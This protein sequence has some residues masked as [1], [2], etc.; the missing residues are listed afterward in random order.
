[1][2]NLYALLIGINNYPID[3]HKL[4][5]CINDRNAMNDFFKSYCETNDLNYQPLLLSDEEAT[6]QGIIDGFEQFKDA[7]TGDLC[8]LYFSGHGSQMIAPK[9]F[10][11]DE[12]DQRCETVV[13]HDSRIGKGRDLSDKELSYLIW[14]YTH[15]KDVHFLATFD[16]CHAGTITRSVEMVHRMAEV[17]TTPVF[18][19]R[20]EGVEFYKSHEGQLIPPESDHIALSASR[21]YESSVELTLG[22]Q[23]RGLFTY[24]LIDVLTQT[25]LTTLSYSGLMSKVQTRVHSRIDSQHP[26]VDAQG[27]A[28]IKQL[29]LD[30][31]LKTNPSY[32]VKHNEKKGWVI[33]LGTIHGMNT[34]AK[35]QLE[36]NDEIKNISLQ[37]IGT[38]QSI[39]R[40]E[41]WMKTDD[42]FYPIKEISGLRKKVKIAFYPKLENP[43]AKQ[44]IHDFVK[45]WNIE[46]VNDIDAAAYWM[47]LT[48]DGYILTRPH[49]SRPVFKAIPEES[50]EELF[51][52]NV[53]KVA[54]WE[55][56][57]QL[58]N[59]LA[60]DAAEQEL[61]IDF[62]QV[63]DHDNY[64]KVNQEEAMDI[65]GDAVF[66]YA[67]NEGKW[68]N[69]NLRMSVSN[70][71]DRPLW[72][73]ALFLGE[74][75]VITDYFMPV[76]ELKPNQQSYALTA[77]NQEGIRVNVVP[78]YVPDELHSWGE[79]EISNQIKIIASATP[80]SMEAY[81]QEGLELEAKPKEGTSRGMGFGSPKPSLPKI[82]TQ[83]D[84]F[85]KDII[86][87]IHRS[88]DVQEAVAGKT[89]TL[90]NLTIE[91]HDSFSAKKIRLTSS[92]NEQ[93]GVSRGVQ[94]PSIQNVLG[95][96][97]FLPINIG[98]GS[99]S[100]QHGLDTL[101]LHDV[102]G[103]ENVT[104]ENPLRLKLNLPLKNNE[105][106]FPF[107]YDAETNTYYP[108]GYPEDDV[109]KVESLADAEE[110][111][112]RGLGRSFKIYLQKVVYQKLFKKEFPFPVLAAATVDEQ[113]NVTYEND[114]DVIKN[115]VQNPDNQRIIIFIHG[116]IGD[117]KDQV[118]LVRRAVRNEGGAKVDLTNHYDLVLTF[119]Y[120]SLN[121]PIE[122]TAEN[123]KKRLE[124]IGLVAG[125]NK[126]LHII[127]HS[128]GGLVSRWFIEKLG[129][130]QIVTHFIQVG[131]PNAGSPWAKAYHMGV[132]GLTKLI[133]FLPIPSTINSVLSFIGKKRKNVEVTVGQLQPD[134]DFSK[135]LNS[136]SPHVKI[137]YTILAGDSS[138]IPNRQQEATLFKKMLNRYSNEYRKK[139][140]KLFFHDRSD[141]IVAVASC[142]GI[143]DENCKNVTTVDSVGCNHFT[144]FNTDE[145]VTALAKILF[146]IK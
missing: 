115:K 24:S 116:I 95:S 55:E 64:L 129:G 109:I 141:D 74:D 23:R 100:I 1:M 145:G 120:E 88:Q 112:T 90:Q 20:F 57:S 96:D 70:K 27:Q 131:S 18:A 63:T 84:W 73:G 125:H 69:P 19:K 80:F 87:K 75:F 65:N 99:R 139:L 111:V 60:S 85:T 137:P 38:S 29:F 44:Y 10:W 28:S 123:L 2:K 113:H 4:N 130:D 122:T 134:S 17:N 107:G 3:S 61:E 53:N 72:I 98:G 58:S 110:V 14:K 106:I 105:S 68:E 62:F 81:L 50:G 21:S 97:N 93:Q 119:D 126:S 31:N 104:A 114:Y 82:S 47:R 46:L 49:N 101:E 45:D 142:H 143:P 140:I 41:A 11:R 83:P 26:Q 78:I 59:P 144:Y 42:K 25:D 92:K 9:E 22:G 36:H 67:Y 91:G 121:D 8:V 37:S 34:N 43:Q 12:T 117:T 108:L 124:Q 136:G 79:T 7:K 133:N 138:L 77:V 52:Q 71:S 89:M 35:I 39:I 94:R 103:K 102:E 132:F 40:E 128:M 86:Y 15:N 118:K 48:D 127:A 66:R 13:C 56:V 16:C 6:R 146:E 5:G 30:G 51:L 54:K 33:D 135:K 32:I 76:K